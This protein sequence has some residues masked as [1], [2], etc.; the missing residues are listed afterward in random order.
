MASK[1]QRQAVARYDATHT[2]QFKLKLNKAT[3]ADIIEVLESVENRQ[4]YLKELIRADIQNRR[5]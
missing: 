4:A 3:D 1:A 5:N 2:V